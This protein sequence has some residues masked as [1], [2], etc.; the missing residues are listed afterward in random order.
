MSKIRSFRDLEVW[1]LGIALV[2]R[3]YRLVKSLSPFDRFIFGPQIIKAAV[4][5]PANTAEGT[6]RPRGAYINH[7]S[8]ALGSEAELETHLE[9]LRQLNLG[10][11]ALLTETD[12]LAHSVGRLLN[13]LHT[14]L[15]ALGDMSDR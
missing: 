5:I 15:K 7:V 3:C 10:Q 4:S 14:S 8:I 12:D 13:G 11:P 9:V 6:R 2:V 1:Q